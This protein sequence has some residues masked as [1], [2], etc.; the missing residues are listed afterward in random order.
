MI[1]HCIKTK[2]VLQFRMREVFG[3]FISVGIVNTVVQV[4]I[5]QLFYDIK[6][7]ILGSQSFFHWFITGLSCSCHEGEIDWVVGLGIWLSITVESISLLAAH[8]YLHH[9]GQPCVPDLS[10]K[11]KSPFF[12]MLLGATCSFA[13]KVVC[14]GRKQILR[15]EALWRRIWDRNESG[16]TTD[17]SLQQHVLCC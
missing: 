7:Q 12:S 3:V 10:K 14:L 15:Y 8:R 6:C 17:L 11:I 13:A 9:Q 2:I 1:Y 5:W 4:W 16:N